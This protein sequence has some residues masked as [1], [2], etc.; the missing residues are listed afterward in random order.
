MVGPMHRLEQIM[1]QKKWPLDETNSTH[2]NYEKPI[3]SFGNQIGISNLIVYEDDYFDRWKN[4]LIV[5]TLASQKLIRL[6]FNEKKKSLI[7]F[8]NISINKRIRDIIKLN[9][10]KIALLTDRGNL[11]E[12][13]AKIIIVELKENN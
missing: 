10:G 12:G 6:V 13:I 7:Y 1:L 2:S 4:N 8:E 5:S 3:L 11:P 9:N